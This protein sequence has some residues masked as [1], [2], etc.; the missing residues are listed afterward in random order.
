M[1]TTVGS[2]VWYECNDNY[3]FPEGVEEVNRTCLSDGNWSEQNLTCSELGKFERWG[4]GDVRVLSVISLA[5][6]LCYI[7][8]PFGNV[9]CIE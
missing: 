9:K 7:I 3:A 1:N 4:G 6:V 5:S 2:T 8:V